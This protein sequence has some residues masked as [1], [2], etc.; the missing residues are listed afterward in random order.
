MVS[1]FFSAFTK[2]GNRLPEIAA[3]YRQI[4]GGDLEKHENI[5][6]LK[7]DVL[8]QGPHCSN[9]KHPDPLGLNHCKGL[10]I[11][12]GKPSELQ[13]ARLICKNCILYFSNRKAPRRQDRG[14]GG[15][16]QREFAYF[17]NSIKASIF[18]IS[19]SFMLTS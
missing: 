16:G 6:H 9:I 15:V 17:R 3:A 7:I 8:H 1:S 5:K 14:S 18:P 12:L 4:F 13:S 10:S 11:I 19:R 2:G